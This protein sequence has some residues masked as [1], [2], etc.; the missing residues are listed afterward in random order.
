MFAELSADDALVVARLLSALQCAGAGAGAT[1]QARIGARLELLVYDASLVWMHHIAV[2]HLSTPELAASAEAVAGASAEAP[3]EA[4]AGATA[5]AGA[6]SAA[7]VAVDMPLG[8]LA[9][10]LRLA[11]NIGIVRLTL[12]PGVCQVAARGRHNTVVHAL[13]AAPGRD[14]YALLASAAAAVRGARTVAVRAAHLAQALASSAE[15]SEDEVELAL[16]TRQVEFHHGEWRAGIPCYVL[17]AGADARVCVAARLLCAL[18]RV[19]KAQA[20]PHVAIAYRADSPL[21]LATDN[22]VCAYTAY[23]APVVDDRAPRE[24]PCPGTL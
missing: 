16:G 13:G 6:V 22:G 24:A 7:A 12:E 18:A 23:V 21:C 8:K 10:A 2:S 19:A 3:A 5:G 14:Y 20:A 4:A 1:C 11:A 15:G 9:R 17:H